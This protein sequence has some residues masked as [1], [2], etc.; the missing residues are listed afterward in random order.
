[1]VIPGKDSEP[2][3]LSISSWQVISFTTTSMKISIEFENPLY[4][5]KNNYKD[6]LKV[7]FLRGEYF[8]G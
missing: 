8:I 4:V 2:S 7:E 5:S 3:L 1:M 6:D